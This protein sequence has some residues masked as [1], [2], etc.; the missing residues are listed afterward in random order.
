MHTFA[1]GA[2]GIPFFSLRFPAVQCLVT[3]L[4][5]SF[6]LFL[7][8]QSTI[9]GAVTDIHGEPL[10]FAN[11]LLVQALDSSLVRGEITD[12]GGDYRFE[13]VPRG[14]YRIAASMVG[15]ETRYTD[16]IEADQKAAIALDPIVME[17]GVELDEV[18]IIGRKPLYEQKID[19]MVVNVENS[20]VSAGN[21][22]LDILQRSP[23]V[24]VNEQGQSISLVGKD[25]VVV[26][27]N[28]K[29]TYMPMSGVIQMLDGMS[30]DN[31]SSIELITTPPA[32]LDAEGNAGFI[33]IVLK[34]R[35]DLGLNG[36]YSLTGGVGNG[37][38]TNDN[39]QFNYRTGMLN[40][41]GN[42]GFV[43]EEQGQFF[44]SD[45]TIFRDTLFESNTITDREPIQR[46]HN[47]RLGADLQVTDKTILG[48]LLTAYNNK[49]TMES[50]NDNY[51]DENGQLVS[52][53]QIFNVEKNQWFHYGGNLNIRHDFSEHQYLSADLDYLYY[54]DEN[55]NTY[56]NDFFDGDGILIK[57]EDTRSD[58]I[59]PLN[60]TVA[61]IDYHT[62]MGERLGIDFGAKTSVSHLENTVTVET[63]LGSEWVVD[64]EYSN[65]GELNERVYAAY[66]SGDYQ[67]GTNTSIRAGLRYEFTDS[68]L[69]TEN[70]GRVVD[71]EFGEVF[72]SIF[73]N[74]QFTE[75]L[76]INLSYSRRITRPTFNEMAP[77]VI[78]LDPNTYFSG[79]TGLQP[80]ISNTIKADFIYKSLFVSLQ[81][82][83]EDSTI[84]RFQQRIDEANNRLFFEPLNLKESRNASLIIG[85]PL[86]PTKWWELR[87]NLM[88]AYLYNSGY[89]DQTLITQETFAWNANLTSIL[90]LGK[91]WSAE[92]N[93]N[94]NSP[95][96]FGLSKFEAFSILTA[97]I[98][99]DFGEKWGSLKFN[100][101]DILESLKWDV[102]TTY[103]SSRSFGSFDFSN[104][105]FSLTY[106]RNFG[107]KRLSDSR[108]RAT[109]A[110][111]ERQRVN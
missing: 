74:H 49:W 59:T 95:S 52:S 28:G 93:F 77:F 92:A 105:T 41:Y 99:K 110:E 67:I 16:Q 1:Y 82:A 107:N 60:I 54:R 76:G 53:T 21:T 68:E 17:T 32:H 29:V 94:Y 31:I 62:L 70:E 84:A 25:G 48:T 23:G 111:E 83:V 72:P 65:S 57:T 96:F 63:L 11:V 58:K 98:Q 14:S 20:I 90:T 19:R 6:T 4:L 39:I 101:S 44:E 5:V 42:Y 87:M 15:F 85:L 9:R 69:D 100:V 47:F 78:F 97:G 106:T 51:N 45:R 33:N 88:G 104:R 66:L 73:V 24:I 7:Q 56:V 71:R 13:M 36:S 3:G 27:I 40:L 91:G 81:Y 108:N 8:A 55:P 50:M 80:A 35:N 46:D 37:T 26:M 109:G 86:Y 75:N 103:E 12:A 2:S 34:S 89:N 10:E 30:A 61:K 43:R 79:N 64:P 38:V 102:I 18:R 22:A